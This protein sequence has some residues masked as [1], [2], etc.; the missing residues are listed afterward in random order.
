MSCRGRTVSAGAF[1]TAH[2]VEAA[3]D[4]TYLGTASLRIEVGGTL[5]SLEPTTERFHARFL[6]FSLERASVKRQCQLG[7]LSHVSGSSIF[8]NEL[9]TSRFGRTLSGRRGVCLLPHQTW[10][11]W[12]EPPEKPN[13]VFLTMPIRRVLWDPGRLMTTYIEYIECCA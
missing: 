9:I 2:T 7:C 3:L 4:G 10:N 5:V 1:Q 8:V 6:V 13:P 12:L 11:S